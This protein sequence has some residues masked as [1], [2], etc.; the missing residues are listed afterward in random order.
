MNYNTAY[1]KKTTKLLFKC[2]RTCSY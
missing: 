1:I 2:I